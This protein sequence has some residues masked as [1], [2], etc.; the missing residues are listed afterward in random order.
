VVLMPV[1]AGV[2][3]VRRSLPPGLGQLALPGGFID[4]GESWQQ[5]A[6]RELR[7]ETGLIAEVNELQLLHIETIAGIMLMFCQTQPRRWQ[8]LHFQ[9]DPAE[10]SEVVQLD[11]PCELAFPTHTQ[12]L[13]DYF[14]QRG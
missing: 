3:A 11:Q 12:V 9:L 8:D 2:L 6:V 5:A 1:D 14:R 13:A 4:W 7:E 10:V